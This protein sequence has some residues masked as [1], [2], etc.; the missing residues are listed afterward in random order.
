MPLPTSRSRLLP[1][2]L[3]LACTAHAAD[4]AG[5]FMVKGGGRATCEAFLVAQ[6]ARD[7]EF[8]SLAGWVDGYLSALN[9]SED[10]TYDIAPWQGTE[11]LL[12]AISGQCRKDPSQ[13]FHAA[14]FRITESMRA[15]RLTT[16]SP[17]VK[18]TVGDQAVVMYQAVVVRIQQRLALRGLFDA[19]ATGE[20]D[21]A[22]IEAMKAFQAE[23]K[24]PVTGLPDQ[25]T[26]AN[27]L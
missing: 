2:L 12:A 25:V 6:Q 14:A 3:L 22:T 10:D 4:E 15:A 24:L 11:L 1:A 21:A 17:L 13:T 19:E 20:Y 23:R 16:R 8:V 9:Q 27:L 7:Q 26:L 5:Q 18:A